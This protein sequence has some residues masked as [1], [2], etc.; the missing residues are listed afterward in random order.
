MSA[1]LG[2]T[3]CPEKYGSKNC[4]GASFSPENVRPCVSLEKGLDV[5]TGRVTCTEDEW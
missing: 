2:I 1:P 5:S 4:L 3:T